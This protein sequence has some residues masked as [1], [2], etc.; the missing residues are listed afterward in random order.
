MVRGGGRVWVSLLPFYAPPLSYIYIIPFMLYD[1]GTTVASSSGRH[2][3]LFFCPPLSPC[4]TAKRAVCWS[5]SPMLRYAGKGKR[6]FFAGL[7]WV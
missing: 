4:L 3:P 6:V 2:L 7:D 1:T 5:A